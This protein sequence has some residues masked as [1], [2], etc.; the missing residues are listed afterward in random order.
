MNEERLGRLWETRGEGPPKERVSLRRASGEAALLRGERGSFLALFTDADDEGRLL[1]AREAVLG[2]REKVIGAELVL[3]GEVLQVPPGR[4]D[5]AKRLIALDRAG[6][7]EGRTALL[8]REGRFVGEV[9]DVEARVLGGVLDEDE[10]VLAWLETATEEEVPSPLGA[11][12]ALYHYLLTERRHALVVVGPYGDALVRPLPDAAVVIARVQGREVFQAGGLEWQMPRALEGHAKDLAPVA[13][14]SA[15]ARVLEVARLTLLARGVKQAD[16]VVRRLLQRLRERGAPYGILTA[17]ALAERLSLEAPPDD[18]AV[19]RALRALVAKERSSAALLKWWRAFQLPL[20]VGLELLARLFDDAAGREWA[21]ELHAG[22]REAQLEESDDVVEQAA[23]D[24]VYAEHLL[25]TRRYGAAQVTLEARLA[26]L[27][28]EELLDLL[29]ADDADLTEGAGGQRL[30]I[31][32][33]ELL[34]EARGEGE[35]PDVATVRALAQLQPLAPDRVERLASL[36]EGELA[37]AARQVIAVLSP[38]GLAPLDEG[39]SLSPDGEVFPLQ[40]KALME[41]LRHPT[42]REGHALDR[43]QAFLAAVDV[44]DHASLRS[45]SERLGASHEAA[46]AAL[47]DASMVLGMKG[48]AAYISHGDK[49]VGV[50]AYDGAPPFLVIG[51]KHLDPRSD[52]YLHPWELRFVV[53]SEVAHLRFQH[54]RVTANDVWMGAIEKGRVGVDLVLGMIPVLRGVELIDKV[55]K[56]IDRYKKGPIGRVVKGIDLADRTVTKV[57]GNARK[58]SSP[59]PRE[60]MVATTNDKLIA[61]HRVMQLTADRAGLLLAADLGAALRAI[62]KS[63]H[64]YLAELPV[65]ERHGVAKALSRRDE[66]GEIIHQDLAIRVSSLI[67]FFLS[68]DYRF[69]RARMTTPP[70]ARAAA[71]S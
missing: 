23:V 5:D 42:T 69:L 1:P 37:E 44:P 2:F 59:P 15:D 58:R 24:I 17:W 54:A 56:I 50:R 9:S 10:L 46:W 45:Y 13:G 26:A 12:R 68:E 34:A 3:E 18:E 28:N 33:L 60:Q 71:S 6:A 63:T 16:A 55:G 19:R 61:A 48:V 20:E 31:R 66:A 4:A 41:R 8:R 14:L 21:V 52:F 70:K 36:A 65:V 30:R 39:A 62:F 53:A 51:G 32:V 43:L 25:A 49:A 29:P 27:P 47:A 11:E 67:S 35:R 38:G 40:K 64:A 57:R 7:P 22:L